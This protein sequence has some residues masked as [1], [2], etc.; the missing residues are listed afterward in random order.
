MVHIIITRSRHPISVQLGSPS[1]L[2]IVTIF[3]D[4]SSLH[5]FSVFQGREVDMDDKMSTIPG[6]EKQTKMLTSN[7]HESGPDEMLIAVKVE[8]I[9]RELK[10]CSHHTEMPVDN[11]Y[12]GTPVD[13]FKCNE[14]DKLTVSKVPQDN[15]TG[16]KVGNPEVSIKLEI[17]DNAVDHQCDGADT[18]DGASNICTVPRLETNGDN[19][20]SVETKKDVLLFSNIENKDVS[21]SGGE[22]VDKADNVRGGEDIQKDGSD[23]DVVKIE[24][25]ETALMDYREQEN[26][27][28]IDDTSDSSPD[29]SSE[30]EH[31]EE[32]VQNG[33]ETTTKI[34]K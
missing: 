16:C 34:N 6:K 14:T 32:T 8:N 31:G 20:D 7:S 11:K 28:V 9:D 10:D 23:T 2:P 33:E 17:T 24:A 18:S 19:I 5:M 25:P 13:N 4:S 3:S 21:V 26:V 1:P 15:S 27:V 12:L 30:D 22:N 29:S